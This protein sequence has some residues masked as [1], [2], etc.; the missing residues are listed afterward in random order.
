MLE[1]RLL[2]LFQILY[3]RHLRLVIILVLNS[4]TLW[5]LMDPLV[6]EGLR[7]LHFLDHQEY[8]QHLLDR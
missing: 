8:P 1:I 3:K 4:T 5:R 2:K 7:L 6:L